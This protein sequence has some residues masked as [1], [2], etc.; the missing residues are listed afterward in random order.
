VNAARTAIRR[1]GAA[2]PYTKIL[3]VL[4]MTW[5]MRGE[6]PLRMCI[7]RIS[8]RAGSDV[9]SLRLSRIWL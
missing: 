4:K 7:R 3:R 6:G 8:D 9:G 1:K 2:S 5:G